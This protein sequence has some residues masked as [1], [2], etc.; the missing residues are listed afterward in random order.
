MKATGRV[1]SIPA[2]AGLRL[3]MREIASLMDTGTGIAARE[4]TIIIGTATGTAIIATEIATM[5]AAE[6]TIATR[7]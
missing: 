5:I 4:N 1:Q 6:I 3:A 2:T 7:L